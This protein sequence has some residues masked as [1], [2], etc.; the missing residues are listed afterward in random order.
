MTISDDIRHESAKGG[1]LLDGYLSSL[2]PDEAASV[3]ELI[4]D[5]TVTN[6]SIARAFTKNGMPLSETSV[7]RYRERLRT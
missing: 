3:V 2:E 1:S 6:V 7:R 5:E 4:R